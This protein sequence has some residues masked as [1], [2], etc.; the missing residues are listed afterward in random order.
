MRAHPRLEGPDL[1]HR[2][3]PRR[4][5][6]GANLGHD[7]EDQGDA[8]PVDQGGRASMPSDSGGRFRRNRA[9]N[10]EARA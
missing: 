7:L 5:L 9:E 8:R 3:R 4:F 6:A 10:P 1:G 2:R